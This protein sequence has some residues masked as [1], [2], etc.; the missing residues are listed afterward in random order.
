MAKHVSVAITAAVLVLLAHPSGLTA[1]DNAPPADRE[2]MAE[3]LRQPLVKEAEKVKYTGTAD[4][5]H[6]EKLGPIVTYWRSR[7]TLKAEFDDPATRLK[8]EVPKMIRGRDT[9][10][11][12]VT[13]IAPVK[14]TVSG[15]AMTDDKRNLFHAD[16]SFTT[17]LVVAAEGVLTRVEDKGEVKVRI[18]VRDWKPALKDTRFGN[19]I[20]NKL[21]GPIEAAAQKRLGEA[22]DPLRNAANKALKKAYDDGKLKLDP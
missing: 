3:L 15:T 6:K 20:V 5:R 18:E 17:T 21:R 14:G 8:V 19:P 9:T 1:Q 11:T 7:V 4:D 12:W 10:T 16:S 22:A 13:V 2:F